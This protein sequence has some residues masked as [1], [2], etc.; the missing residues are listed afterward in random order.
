MDGYEQICNCIS[1]DNIYHIVLVYSWLRSDVMN[2]L[3]SHVKAVCVA[4]GDPQQP[5]LWAD[6]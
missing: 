2:T 3:S 6:P 4:E 5:A 1:F